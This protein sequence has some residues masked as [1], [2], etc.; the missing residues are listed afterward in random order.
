[1][2]CPYCGKL[3]ADSFSFC[4]YCGS[5]LA[6]P[7]D[8]NEGKSNS[9]VLNRNIIDAEQETVLAEDQSLVLEHD[10]SVPCDSKRKRPMIF[11][12][13][14]A[15]VVIG[16]I[17]AIVS[18]LFHKYKEAIPKELTQTTSDSAVTGIYQV[19]K[20]SGTLYY[21]FTQNPYYDD[22]GRYLLVEE[23]IYS[24]ERIYTVAPGRWNSSNGMFVIQTD[25]MA[26]LQSRNSKDSEGYHIFAGTEYIT[27]GNYLFPKEEYF[28]SGNIEQKNTFEAIC[29]SEENEQ[30]VFHRNGTFEYITNAEQQSGSYQRNDEILTLVF[31]DSNITKDYLVYNGGITNNALYKDY[32]RQDELKSELSKIP[33][34]KNHRFD[35]AL[36]IIQSTTK[37]DLSKTFDILEDYKITPDAYIVVIE[38]NTLY[39]L[40]HAESKLCFSNCVPHMYVDMFVYFDLEDNENPQFSFITDSLLFDGLP[41]EEYM[42]KMHIS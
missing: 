33:M 1:M 30:F 14:L 38:D 8:I 2:F 35:E 39:A 31:D 10:N 36:S 22:A 9:V 6:R 4:I 23:A 7:E 19:L 3:N 25:T 5:K 12:A 27:A 18:I 34:G 16:L 11:I 17:I 26:D 28:Y 32:S 15:I 24:D 21:Y 42:E 29:T 37:T 20:G 13:I 40:C 41:G